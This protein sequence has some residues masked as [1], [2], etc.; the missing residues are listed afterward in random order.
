MLQTQI[1]IQDIKHGFPKKIVLTLQRL[2]VKIKEIK[3]N[4]SAD[5]CRVN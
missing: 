3:D 5:S 4:T 1:R 2:A